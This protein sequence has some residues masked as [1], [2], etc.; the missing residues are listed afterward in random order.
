MD[1]NKAG[2][3]IPKKN[4]INEENQPE[5][6]KVSQL[7]NAAQPPSLTKELEDKTIEAFKSNPNTKIEEVKESNEEVIK[8]M[9]NQ[10]NSC[11]KREKMIKSKMDSL[12]Q[13]QTFLTDPKWR[14]LKGNS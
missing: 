4:P 7:R 14:T 5:N 9:R 2:S 1:S 11:R 3:S 6:L 13:E 12:K 8:K 10:I